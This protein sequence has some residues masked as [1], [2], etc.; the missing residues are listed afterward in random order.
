MKVVHICL[1]GPYTDGFAYQ[2]NILPQKHSELG[3]EVNMLV[4]QR[5]YNNKG[6]VIFRACKDYKDSR[7][8]EISILPYD[9]KYG[10][11]AVRLGIFKSLI[12]KLNNIKPDIIFVHGLQFISIKKILT[13]KLKNRDVKIYIDNH[14]DLY[15][16]SVR[17]YKK[18]NDTNGFIWISREKI[19]TIC[20]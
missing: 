2:D 19:S 11:I 9:R 16:Y 1:C 10:R 3:Y 4:S 5:S 17:Q 8:I 7:G 18:I 12:L 13:Y 6:N 15:K 14:A 20:R